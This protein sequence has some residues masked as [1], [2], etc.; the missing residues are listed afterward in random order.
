MSVDSFP[1]AVSAVDTAIEKQKFGKACGPDGVCMEAFISGGHLL[2]MLLCLLFNACITYGYLWSS[3]I[4]RYEPVQLLAPPGGTN[5]T[6]IF[7]K[8]QYP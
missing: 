8:V 2:R 7:L 5:A 1:I 4:S 3:A 6:N